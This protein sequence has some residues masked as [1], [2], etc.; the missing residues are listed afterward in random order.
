MEQ[1]I[2]AIVA[3]G[4]QPFEV[5]G[6]VR[7]RL[8]GAPCKDVDIEVFRLDAG[9]LGDIL[10]QFG[11]LD[12]VGVSFGVLKLRTPEGMEF[13]FTLPRRES[14]TGSGHRGFAV[15]VD[16]MMTIEDAAA[17]RD[18]TI[19][20]IY[21][22]PLEDRILDPYGG[23][24]DLKSQVL[25][26][27]SHH[28]AEDPLQVLRGMQF[29]SR[30][31]LTVEADTARMC[32]SLRSEAQT[33]AVERVWG[34]WHKWATRGRHPAAG[35]RFLQEAEW[36]LLYPELAALV[37]VPQDPVWHPEGDVWIHTLLVCDAAAEIA[38]REKLDERER[39]ILLFAA[40]CH[41]LGKATTT[42]FKN[43]RWRAH[44]HPQAGVPLT[45]SFL[46]RI[47]CPNSIIEI[48]EPLV[49]EHLVHAADKLTA[50]SARRLARR[51]GQATVQQLLYLIEA[52][53]RGRP[54]LP[55]DL[56]ASVLQLR[57][58][59]TTENVMFSQP[60]PLVMGRHLIRMGHRPGDWFGPIL[61]NCY[62][63]QLD[64]EFSD[65]QAGLVWLTEYL[66]KF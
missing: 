29:A 4:G 39:S 26:A 51:L 28:F 33:L 35:L 44:G 1:I 7:D 34:E 38:V 63:A 64:G 45:R 59:A 9:R 48:V 24:N 62:E 57:T 5:G 11:R 30:F 18:F 14:K 12:S 37:G 58:L 55:G 23:T 52:D 16:H 32:C 25:R 20:A 15:E 42:E 6:C 41:D 22:C 21:R 17:R 2:D 36:L 43:G 46:E 31:G 65:E 56:P 13:D 61:K 47:A 40:L 19:N 50:H 3:G 54:P 49:A 53:L 8:L 66:R 60:S 27:T 10:A